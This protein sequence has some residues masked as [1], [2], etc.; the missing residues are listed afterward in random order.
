MLITLDFSSQIPIYMQLRNAVVRGVAEGRLQPGEK[1]P[2]VRRLAEET[3]VNWMTVQKAYQLL[4]QEG[5]IE[6]D[7]RSGARVSAAMA[8]PLR[9][10]EGGLA[11]LFQAA[12][13]SGAG[14]AEVLAL[15]ERLLGEAEAGTEKETEKETEREGRA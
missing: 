13:A 12:L 5:F 3:G 14:R 9:A 10:L 6:T 2:A 15:C 7:R 11:Q 4:K 8:D 1:L